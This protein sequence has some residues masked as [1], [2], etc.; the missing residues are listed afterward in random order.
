MVH[1]SKR[2]IVR[3]GGERT[4]DENFQRRENQQEELD[5]GKRT[6]RKAV[7]APER[8][9]TSRKERRKRRA[10][11]NDT[12]S[13]KTERRIGR[14]NAGEWKRELPKKCRLGRKT[15]DRNG[16]PNNHDRIPTYTE[17]IHNN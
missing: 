8:E 2:I 10:A 15:K 12:Q 9:Q 13:S 4:E 16:E 3:L 6:A 5:L 7:E 14:K 11:C 17:E 1:T